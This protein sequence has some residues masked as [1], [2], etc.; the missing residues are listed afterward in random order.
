MKSIEK[1]QID[2]MTIKIKEKVEWKKSILKFFDDK[3]KRKNV[4]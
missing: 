4:L 3:G 1:T 2:F